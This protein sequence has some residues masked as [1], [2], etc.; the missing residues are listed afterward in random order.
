[1][2]RRVTIQDVA[3]KAGVGKVTVSYVLN[4]RADDARISHATR[5]RILAAAHE[6][7]YR[8][9]AIG[10]MLARKQSD[11]IAVVFQYGSFFSANSSFTIEVMRAVCAACVEAGVDVMLH[12]K[13]AGDPLQEAD[14][15]SDG[16]VDAVLMIRD[17]CDPCHEALVDR[18]FPA[19]LFFCRSDLPEASYVVCDN[20]AGGRLATQHLL[21]LGHRRIGMLRGG[22]RSVDSNDRFNGYRSALESSGIPYDPSLV[23]PYFGLGDDPETVLRLMAREDRP[24][25]LFV[26][27]DDAAQS[28]LHVLRLDGFSVPEDVSVVGFDGTDASAQTVPPLTTIRQP[29]HEIA[30]QAVQAALALARGEEGPRQV[31]LPPALLLRGSTSAP[32]SHS[33]T[34]RSLS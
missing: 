28:L 4:G 29:I 22:P 21:S 24:T 18:D 31:V 15:L 20:Y 13:P 26:W 33:M 12:T 9:N 5:D 19:V 25:G 17:D 23:V 3:D 7:H 27:S 16:R 6:L 10:R 2:S 32:L 1:M 30:T 34:K 8:P 11:A 14:N